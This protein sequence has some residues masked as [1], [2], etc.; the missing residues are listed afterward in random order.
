MKQA[1]QIIESITAARPVVMFSGG[2]DSLL[3]LLLAREKYSKCDVLWYRMGSKKQREQIEYWRNKLNL[4]IYSYRPSDYYYLPLSTGAAL[5]K[6]FSIKGI[7]FP[8]V[9]EVAEGER[10]GLTINESKLIRF[11][12]SWDV[13]FTGWK[14]CDE[15]DL[16]SGKVNYAL[17]ETNV[18]GSRFY[19]PIRHMADDEVRAHLKILAPEFEEFDDSVPLCTR[20]FTQSGEVFC[21][22][23]QTMIP[24]ALLGQDGLTA[25]RERF[26]GH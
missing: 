23:E 15:H 3:T 25:F 2:K 20:C 12:Y 1:R 6:E 17:D 16:M 9:A 5:V 26:G 22:Q 14:D 8:A 13:T 18:G 19:A 11:N 4:T 24:A 7:A 10:C 21:P